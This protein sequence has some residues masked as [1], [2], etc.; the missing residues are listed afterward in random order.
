MDLKY[1]EVPL[2]GSLKPLEK[3]VKVVSLFSGLGG[4]S[5]GYKMAGASVKLAVE[6]LDYQAETYRRNNPSTIVLQ[7]NIRELEPDQI[8]KLLKLKKGELDIL[9]GSPPCS[10]FSTAGIRE[11]GWGREKKY[12]NTTQ[13]V[14]DLF[15]EYI[16]FIKG[17][18]PK[19]F[20]AENVSGLVKGKAKGYFKEIMAELTALGYTV[21]AKLLNAKYYGVPQSRQ[22]L[23][24]IGVRNDLNLAPAFPEANPNVV[25]LKEAFKNIVNTEEDLESANIQ[26]FAIYREALKTSSANRKSSKYMSMVK[27]MPNRPSDTLTA[28]AGNLGAASVFHWDNRKFTVNECR[29][30]A[31]FPSDFQ[32]SGTWAEQ[33]EGFGRAVP[34]LMMKAVAS[35]IIEQILGKIISRVKR[36]IK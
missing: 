5:L 32:M 15:F 23:I 1:G 6:F 28:T 27:Q 17:I 31:S 3:E 36:K 12:G 18:Q 24:I 21:K 8:L 33:I 16:R 25:T 2:L 11:A 9:D 34:P 29:A 14:D 4:S 7:E 22:R 20:V 13:V 10:A 30:I 26:R 35:T 19:V